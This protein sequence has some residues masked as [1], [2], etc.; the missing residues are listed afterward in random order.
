MHEFIPTGKELGEGKIRSFY[1]VELLSSSGERA[2]Y[3]ATRQE[4]MWKDRFIQSAEFELARLLQESGLKRENHRLVLPLAYQK[5]GSTP[6]QIAQREKIVPAKLFPD[7][8]LSQ[9]EIYYPLIADGSNLLDV[10]MRSEYE[11]A[12]SYLPLPRVLT[13]I[14]DVATGIDVLRKFGFVNNDIKLSNILVEMNRA[15]VADFN[16]ANKYEDNTTDRRKFFHLVQ[17]L[18]VGREVN[19]LFLSG[20]PK[21]TKENFVQ[22][23]RTLD[24]VSPS[25]KTGYSSDTDG[26]IRRIMLTHYPEVVQL[27]IDKYWNDS[28]LPLVDFA[29]ELTNLLNRE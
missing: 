9:I 1:E 27:L 13:I 14:Q 10:V 4:L 15:W 24:D 29:H 6:E 23:L 28:K 3:A 8:D 2:Q 20:R 19:A 5:V 16:V 25:N 11:N 12:V 26:T 17:M 21:C 18:L 7:E 22:G